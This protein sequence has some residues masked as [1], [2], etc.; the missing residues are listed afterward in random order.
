[1]IEVR[2]IGKGDQSWLHANRERLFNGEIIVSR[3]VVHH[4]LEKPGFIALKNGEPVGVAIYDIVGNNCEL[5]SIEALAQWQG[6]GSKLICQVESMAREL[7]STNVWL[8]TTNDN[9]DAMRFYQKRGF[10]LRAVHAG[11][12]ELSRTIKPAIPLIGNYG[13][14]MTDEV[15][16]YKEL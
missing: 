13:I 6:I 4:V 9:L 11:A 8:I 1:M 7:E 10:R 5:V 16:L 15:E 2:A 3:G 12:L 14:A